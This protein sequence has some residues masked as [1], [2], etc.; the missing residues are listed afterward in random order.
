[1]DLPANPRAMDALAL[2][3]CVVKMEQFGAPQARHRVVLIGIR[4]DLVATARIQLKVEYP[5]SCV[6]DVL[7]D[8]PALR[9]R[10]SDRSDSAGVWREVLAG[11]PLDAWS[12]EL[13]AAAEATGGST[14]SVDALVGKIRQATVPRAGTGG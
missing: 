3:S 11:A 13:L 14:Q 1:L 10:I 7:S 5:Q 2:R 12:K 6:A 4:E 8:L 9:S